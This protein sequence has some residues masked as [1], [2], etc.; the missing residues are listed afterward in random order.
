MF[1]SSNGTHVRILASHP[2]VITVTVVNE[3][4][5]SHIAVIDSLPA[6]LEPPPQ[7]D[8]PK[9]I[10]PV[11]GDIA[12]GDPLWECM[13]ADGIFDH[14]DVGLEKGWHVSNLW[15]S[16]RVV[17]QRG[18]MVFSSNLHPGRHQFSYVALA[19]TVGE[20]YAPPARVEEM[21]M[22]DNVL[23]CSEASYVHIE[24]I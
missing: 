20:F 16:D 2:V 5:L 22:H 12:Q 3:E 18:A 24:A 19:T 10:Y 21:Y 23:G 13:N 17:H 8:T 6:G 14:R 1:H 9:P 15:A 7:P 4:P 11:G